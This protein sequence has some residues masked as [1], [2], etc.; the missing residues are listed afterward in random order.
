[1]DYIGV[2]KKISKF[3]QLYSQLKNSELINFLLYILHI[4]R[5]Q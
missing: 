3:C 4:L 1:M 5:I 2:L